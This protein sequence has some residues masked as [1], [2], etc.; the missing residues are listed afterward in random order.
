[1]NAYSRIDTAISW[2]LDQEK[3]ANLVMIYIEEPDKQSHALGVHTDEIL[4]VLPKIDK[5][6]Q[7]LDDKL[8]Q[9]HL[10]HRTN[11]IHLS[12]HGMLNG[13]AKK[14]FNLTDF[15]K[16]YRYERGGSSPVTSL[17][18]KNAEDIEPMY[19]KL[20]NHERQFTPYKYNELPER[21]R[22]KNKDRTGDIT[23]VANPNFGFDEERLNKPSKLLN[24]QYAK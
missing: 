13:E 7:Y 10:K 3:P 9:N 11:I 8:E 14:N 22:F 2:I 23:V 16:E 18:V 5:L 17:Y 24:I 19:Q 15:L 1:M 21:W 12:D 6:T 4:Q 20:R